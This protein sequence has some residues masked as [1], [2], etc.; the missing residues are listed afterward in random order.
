MLRSRPGNFSGD[1]GA[2]M[3]E[4]RLTKE[5]FVLL[6]IVKDFDQRLLTIKGWGVTLSLAALGFGFQYQH[7]GF[8]L[9]AALSG[10][11]FWAIES[12]TKRH[13]ML[14][15]A[16]LREIEVQVFEQ[17]SEKSFPIVTPQINW[18]WCNAADYYRGLQHGPPLPPKR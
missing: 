10:F 5:Y 2:H 3:A 4:D 15:Y 11:A 1:E 7:Y 8:F 6:D 12:L 13:Q 14:H 16:R 9:V 17:V 18:S